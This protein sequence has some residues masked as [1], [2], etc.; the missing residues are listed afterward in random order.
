MAKIKLVKKDG[1][2]TTRADWSKAIPCLFIL[3]L[4]F[5]IVGALMYLGVASIR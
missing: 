1:S 4:G 5:V 2:K 3:L